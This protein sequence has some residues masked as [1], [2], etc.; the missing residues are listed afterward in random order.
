[1]FKLLGTDKKE[2]GPV[3][4][5]QIKAWIAQ[6]RANARTQLQAAGSTEWKPLAEFP[7]FGAVLQ[8][9]KTGQTI[10]WPVHK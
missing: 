10:G 8:H 4:A 6:G 3:S 9:A 2:Y 5:D 7:E 1:M